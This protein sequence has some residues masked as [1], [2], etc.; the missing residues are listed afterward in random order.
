VK[1]PARTKFNLPVMD[2]SWCDT[3]NNQS[4]YGSFFLFLAFSTAKKKE[5]KRREENRTRTAK[6]NF[7]RN[8]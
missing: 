5:E 6:P 3:C 2:H 4:I 8:A 7:K 1:H